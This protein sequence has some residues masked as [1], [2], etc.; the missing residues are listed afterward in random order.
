MTASL[1]RINELSERTEAFLFQEGD[2]LPLAKLAR[3][4]ECTKEELRAALDLLRERG[5]GRGIAL[6]QTE[7]EAVLAVSPSSA[8][9]IRAAFEKELGREIGDAGLEV[10]AILLYRGSSTRAEIDYIRGVNTSWTIR[11]LV[12]RKLLERTPNP[13]DGREYL[14]HPTSELLAHLGVTSV[15]ELPEYATISRELAE[16]ESTRE[17]TENE[18][19]DNTENAEPS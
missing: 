16:F 18:H 5:A 8:P 15:T 1:E 6:V 7:T 12:A 2:S 10:L 14:Y 3:L 19:P 11:M 9:A 13:K 17:R 4:L